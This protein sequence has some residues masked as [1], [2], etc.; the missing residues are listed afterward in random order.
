MKEFD[1]HKFSNGQ[2]KRLTNLPNLDSLR[3]LTRLRG[4]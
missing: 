4:E 1:I 2:R 3:N